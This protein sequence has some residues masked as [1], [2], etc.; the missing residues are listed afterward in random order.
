M[1]LRRRT[2]REGLGCSEVLSGTHRDRRAE[3]SGLAF[4]LGVVLELRTDPH[5]MGS[6]PDRGVRRGG[7]LADA[8]GVA[9]ASGSGKSAA[10][11]AEAA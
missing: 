2:R 9:V 7:G 1:T 4:V 5:T 10:P 11:P 8:R 3:R 6:A